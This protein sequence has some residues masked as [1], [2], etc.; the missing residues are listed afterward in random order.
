[1][2]TEIS[3]KKLLEALL[4]SYIETHDLGQIYNGDGTLLTTLDQATKFIDG[5]KGETMIEK[6]TMPCIHMNGSD[7]DSLRRQYNELFDAVSQAQIKLLYDTDFHQRDYY[8]LGEL[9]WSEANLEREEIKEAMNKVYQ[10]AKQH[11]HYLDYG[12]EPLPDES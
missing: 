8:P 1:M 6:Y 11:M 7:E 9:V 2:N 4:H 12:K 10:Y 5:L 3:T